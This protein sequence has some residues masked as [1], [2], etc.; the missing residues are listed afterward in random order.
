[1]RKRVGEC[2]AVRVLGR[3]KVREERRAGAGF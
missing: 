3:G 1:M 2:V